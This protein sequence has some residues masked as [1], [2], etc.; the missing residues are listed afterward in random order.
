MPRF[1]TPYYHFRR[2]DISNFTV[3]VELH[4]ADEPDYELLHSKMEEAGFTR[5]IEGRGKKLWAFPKA[6]YNLEGGGDKQDVLKA[7][8]AAAE[9]TGRKYSILVTESN[10]RTWWNLPE[11]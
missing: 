6:E 5:T 10:G 4:S 7:A 9:S 3:R 1:E 11:A 2:N 8:R